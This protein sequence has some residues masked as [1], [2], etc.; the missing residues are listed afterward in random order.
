MSSK[1]MKADVAGVGKL[2]SERG[3]F[4]VPDHQREYAWPNG[5][6]EQ[7][8]DDIDS[9][10]KNNEPDYFVGLIVLVEPESD[11]AWEILDG[12]QR[13][14][15]TTMIYSAIRSWLK[16][17]GFEKDAQKVQENYIGISELGEKTDR[18]RIALNVRDRE[19]FEIAVANQ[20]SDDYLETQRKKSG[21]NSSTRKLIE[22]TIACRNY[23]LNLAKEAGDD[24]NE[25]AKKLFSLANYLT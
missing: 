1:Y 15:T 14:A 13:L 18:P 16:E 3:N 23:I 11:G 8:L 22:A 20:V 21:R 4:R 7:F 6:V 19:I 5:A 17:N 2:I 10:V 9:A 25:Q 12:Q 24:R